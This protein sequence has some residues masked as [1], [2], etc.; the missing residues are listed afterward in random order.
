MCAGPTTLAAL[1]QAI[2][3]IERGPLVEM[4]AAGAPVPLGDARVDALLGGGLVRGAL[5]EVFSRTPAD[6]ATATAF[7]AGLTQR[8]SGERTVLWIGQ[9][10]VAIEGGDLSGNGLAALGLAPERLL[11]VRTPDAEAALKAAG[12]GLACAA[13]GAVVIEPWGAPK[14]LDLSATRRLALAAA[15]AEVPALLLRVAAA[16]EPSAAETRWVVAAAPSP[17]GE[18]FGRPVFAAELVRNR[19]G[20]TG[21]WIMEWNADERLFREP[22]P[23]GRPAHP[24]AAP[25]AAFDRPGAAE[26]LARRA[27]G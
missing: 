20:A 16:P 19:R 18:A 17:P 26:G 8:L 23:L 4:A 14:L 13:L 7:A 24:R 12:E 3:R 1:R 10:F 27:A 22:R 6:A 9:D 5:H 25:A 11:F 15:K 2:G 21:A